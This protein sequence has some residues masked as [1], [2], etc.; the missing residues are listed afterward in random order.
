MVRQRRTVGSGVVLGVLVLAVACQ[1]DEA[2]AVK[3][4]EELGGRVTVD[5][6]RPGKPVAAVDSPV[7]R[8]RTR[9]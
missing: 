5:A 9:G 1:A 2:V 4:I 6:K 7:P 8:S 3:A